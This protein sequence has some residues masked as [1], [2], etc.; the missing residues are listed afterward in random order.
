[1]KGVDEN[2][3]NVDLIVYIEFRGFMDLDIKFGGF[4]MMDLKSLMLSILAVQAS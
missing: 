1:M 4:M 2:S 3:S